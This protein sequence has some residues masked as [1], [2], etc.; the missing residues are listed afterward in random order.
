MLQPWLLGLLAYPIFNTA[1]SVIKHCQDAVTPKIGSVVYCDLA[2]GFAD[3]SGIY[4]GNG[5]IVHLTADG[6][7]EKVSTEEFMVN[8]TALGIYVSCK[9]NE[10][11]GSFAVAD[12]ALSRVNQKSRYSLLADNCHRFTS[13]CLTGQIN[14]TDSFMWMLKLT[15]NQVMHA[16]SWRRCESFLTNL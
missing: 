2:F 1:E 6:L 16:D 15:A 11:V 14:N 5:E 3:H 13:S 4:V 8:T 10:A 7:I 9:K 12:R